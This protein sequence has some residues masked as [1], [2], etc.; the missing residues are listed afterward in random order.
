MYDIEL[1]DC[2]LG[3]AKVIYMASS[4]R[5]RYI[6]GV[7]GALFVHWFFPENLRILRRLLNKEVSS[8]VN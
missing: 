1:S 3:M 6:Y 7:L 2:D 5:M 4:D 8:D